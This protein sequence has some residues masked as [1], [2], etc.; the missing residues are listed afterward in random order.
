MA[1][2]LD[3][4][5]KYIC[6]CGNW[7]VTNLQL[8]KILYMAQMA[9]MG[10][11]DGDRLADAEFEAWDYGPVEPTLYRK[12][13]M[14]GARPIQDVFYHARRFKDEDQR[15]QVLDDVCKALL[16]LRPAQLVDMTHWDG[17]AWAKHYVPGLRGLKIPDAD[18]ASEYA[19]RRDLLASAGV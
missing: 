9:Y 4:V 12:V 1:A 18:I 14:F 15:R 3:S 17:G 2:R 11:N 7:T 10:E 5:S 16:P 6:E 19:A 13:R 8:Q